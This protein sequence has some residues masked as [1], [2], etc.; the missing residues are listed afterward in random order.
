VIS[1]LIGEASGAGLRAFL[2]IDTADDIQH[3]CEQVV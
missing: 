1:N 3:G 2:E